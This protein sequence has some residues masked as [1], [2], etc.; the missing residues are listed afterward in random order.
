VPSWNFLTNHGRVLLCI[1][2]DPSIRLRDIADTLDIT[3]RRAHDIVNDLAD[4]GYLLKERDGRRNR[5]EI[6]G[7]LPFPD[8][9]E[10]ERAIGDVLAV[11]TGRRPNRS[12]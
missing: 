11:L 10:R 3:E 4:E 9:L 5:Y 6:Q 2:R 8:A 1:A 7:H 12:T